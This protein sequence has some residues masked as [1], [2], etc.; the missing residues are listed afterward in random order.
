[1]AIRRHDVSVCSGC[2][3]DRMMER[4]DIE[5]LSRSDIRQVRELAKTCLHYMHVVGEFI[6]EEKRLSD[7]EAD[8]IVFCGKCGKQR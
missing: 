1:L 3:F 2:G 6:D 8:G 7:I 4:K 5:P